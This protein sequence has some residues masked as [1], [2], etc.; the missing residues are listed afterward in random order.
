MPAKTVFISS[1]RRGLEEERDSAPALI[2]AIG[3]IPRRFEDFTAQPR[4]SRDTCLAGVEEAD[5]Y[6]LLLGPHYGDLLPDSGFSPTEEEWRVAK[7]RGIPIVVF[8]QLEVEMDAAQAEFVRRVEDYVTGRFRKTFGT[9]SELLPKIAAVLR[10]LDQEAEALEWTPLDE[11][12]AIDW[13]IAEHQQPYLGVGP[14]MELHIVPVDRPTRIPAARLEAIPEQIARA[15]REHDLFSAGDALD[16]R[17]N[18]TSAIGSRSSGRDVASAGLAVH[19]DQVVT[20]WEELPRDSMGAILDRGDV[21]SRLARLLRVGTE[22]LNPNSSRVGIAVGVGPTQNL[23]EGDIRDLGRRNSSTMDM[24][25]RLVRVD[26]EDAVPAS[27]LRPAADE[28]A[29]ELATRLLMRSGP[30]EPSAIVRRLHSPRQPNPNLAVECVENGER[31][32]LGTR[33]AGAG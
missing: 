19:S 6:L 17:A 21:E 3:H 33:P 16:L 32:A 14:T 20:A 9:S 22:M 30:D 1:V 4:P 2:S 26:A 15:G 27:T 13:V 8:R 29:A 24:G 7:R 25:D 5:V 11:P 10:A 28:I 18:E 23:S 31:A 12:V